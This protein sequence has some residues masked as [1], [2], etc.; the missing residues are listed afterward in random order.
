MFSVLLSALVIK[1]ALL[2]HC[3]PTGAK[4]RHPVSSGAPLNPQSDTSQCIT[5]MSMRMALEIIIQIDEEATHHHLDPKDLAVRDKLV[6]SIINNEPDSG[7]VQVL[8]P[9][10]N[11]PD[12][13]R[14]AWDTLEKIPRRVPGIL[15]PGENAYMTPELVHKTLQIGHQAILKKLLSSYPWDQIPALT[16]NQIKRLAKKLSQRKY[17]SK[18]PAWVQENW[19]SDQ[20][21]RNRIYNLIAIEKRRIEAQHN[22]ASETAVD[23]KAGESSFSLKKTAEGSTYSADDEGVIEDAVN[24]LLQLSKRPRHHTSEVSHPIEMKVPRG[25]RTR[26]LNPSR[27]EY[28]LHAVDHG[29]ENE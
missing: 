5:E 1:L 9:I 23:S 29:N 26:Y 25:K 11:N 14:Q 12:I 15:Q 13:N 20:A 27:F 4:H 3:M 17:G 28:L 24:T 18:V 6:S 22:H 2:G 21:L 7:I 8:T 19:L 16:Q 10:L